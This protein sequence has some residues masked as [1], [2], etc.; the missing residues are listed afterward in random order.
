[1]SFVGGTT[2]EVNGWAEPPKADSTAKA[3]YTRRIDWEKRAA[4]EDEGVKFTGTRFKKKA[5]H[6]RILLIKFGKPG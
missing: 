2:N 4:G 1:V 6:L 5:G 3:T